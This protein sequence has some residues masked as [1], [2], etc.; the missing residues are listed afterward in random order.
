M[1]HTLENHKLFPYIAW[2]TVISFAFFTYT[3]AME[4]QSD[5]DNLN[6]S[7]DGIE[8]SLQE[9]KAERMSAE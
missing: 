9:M 2:A 1:Q 6:E 8:Q 3:L 7:V 5:L 4:L